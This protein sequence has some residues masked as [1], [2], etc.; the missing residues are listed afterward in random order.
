MAKETK[1]KKFIFVRG[2]NPSVVWDPAANKPLAE[3]CDP[4][5][6]KVTGMFVTADE[7]VAERLREAGYKER[8][9]FPEGAP[10]GGFTPIIPEPDLSA[11]GAPFPKKKP[12]IIV[13]EEEEGDEEEEPEVKPKR[14]SIRRRKL[15][16]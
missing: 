16:D 15:N 3:F 10:K 11:P 12:D 8:K 6:K 14:S 1:K 4:D 2:A 5:S 9:D 7:K 13:D